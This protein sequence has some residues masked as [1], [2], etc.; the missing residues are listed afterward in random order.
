MVMCWWLVMADGAD[1][2]SA[3]ANGMDLTDAVGKDSIATA[4]GLAMTA[5]I[6]D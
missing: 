5:A 2:G 4:E 6:L 1:G 3:S